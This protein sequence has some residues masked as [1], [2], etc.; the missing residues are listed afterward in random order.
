LKERRGRP[1][2]VLAEGAAGVA[3]GSG[4]WVEGVDHGAAVLAAREAGL[5]VAGGGHPMAAGLTVETARLTELA[6]FLDAR[7]GA[8]VM[9]ARSGRSLAIDVATTPR[10]FTLDLAEALEAAGPYG[11]GWPAPR[12]AVGP[13]AIVRADAV[14]RTDPPEHLR[15]AARGPDGGRVAG[16]AFRAV[17]GPLG[18]LLASAGTDRQWHLAGRMQINRFQGRAAPELLLD[19]AVEAR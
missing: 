6:A 8:A 3:R 10:G 14:G 15:F 18:A 7:L 17:S 16:V 4:R 12:V 1:A 13:V 11:Q 5:L 19:D 9:A 2:F